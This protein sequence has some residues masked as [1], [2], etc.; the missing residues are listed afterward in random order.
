[1]RLA[2]GETSEL[3]R[4]DASTDCATLRVRRAV[5]Y[6][7]GEFTVGAPKTAAGIRDVAVPPHIRPILE[8]HLK[9]HVAEFSDSL[10]FPGDDGTLVP[11]VAWCTSGPATAVQ[12][13]ATSTRSPQFVYTATR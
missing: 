13:Q 10:L 3:R 1:M 5:T 6:R 11:S 2:L 7:N 9:N 12:R 4:G 8:A